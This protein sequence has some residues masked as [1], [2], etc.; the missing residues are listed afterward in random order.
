MLASRMLAP[1]SSF[2]A[3]SFAM[4]SASPVT[5]FTFTPICVA[6]A[7]V[8]L[9]SARGGSNSGNTPMNCHGAVPFGPGD[10]QGA[11]TSGRKL[12]NG[13]LDGDLGVAVA[14]SEG[15]NDLRRPFRDFESFSV[16]V[17][18]LRLGALVH[19]IKGREVQDLIA[20]QFGAVL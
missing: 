2:F 19:R 7:I 10:T 17:L 5:I 13:F 16:F 11:K 1:M 14:V 18:H 20:F 8:A 12:I 4:A 6:V 9:A 3:V 15:Q